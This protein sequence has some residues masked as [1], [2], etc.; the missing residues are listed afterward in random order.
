[1][2]HPRGVLGRQH[3]ES[4][5]PAGRHGALGGALG[6]DLDQ[7]GG[8]PAAPGEG[9]AGGEQRDRG[10]AVH[11]A[12]TVA[13]AAAIRRTLREP[14]GG[15]QEARSGWRSYSA[16]TSYI[17]PPRRIRGPRHPRSGGPKFVGASSAVNPRKAQALLAPARQLTP[18]A[19]EREDLRVA[20]FILP[21]LAALALAGATSANASTGGGAT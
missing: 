3:R 21:S 6:L 19:H 14:N 13:P 12:L 2:R 7:R 8:A 10:N 11:R 18:Q 9:E 16:P 4:D 5:P 1:E 15:W 17:L 20:H